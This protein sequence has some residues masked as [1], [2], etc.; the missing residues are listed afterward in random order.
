MAC[1]TLSAQQTASS[2]LNHIELGFYFDSNFSVT[3]PILSETEERMKKK[4]NA[5]F[6]RIITE[7]MHPHDN[8]R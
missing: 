4:S 7:K 2:S 6:N 1:Q 3:F 8:L 5:Y